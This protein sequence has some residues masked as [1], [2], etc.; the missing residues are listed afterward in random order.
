MPRLA[1][2]CARGRPHDER[3]S[4]LNKELIAQG[5]ANAGSALCQGI[6]GAQATIRSVLLIKEGARSRLAGVLIGVF[7][8]SASVFSKTI[9]HWCR[10]R[11][12]LACC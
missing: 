6:P 7:A 4:N 10:R 12:S 11:Y 8:C 5:L 9:S 2:D 1:P 3:K